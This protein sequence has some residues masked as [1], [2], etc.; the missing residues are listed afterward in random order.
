MKQPLCRF[1][2]SPLDRE[3]TY[4]IVGLSLSRERVAEGRERVNGGIIAL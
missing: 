2:T 4:L 1:A 3:K